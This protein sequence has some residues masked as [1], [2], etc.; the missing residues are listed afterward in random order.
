MTRPLEPGATIGILGGGQLGRLLAIAAAELGYRPAIF[1]PDPLSPA[2]HVCDRHWQAPYDSRAALAEFADAVDIVTFE[3]ENVPALSLDFL[4]ARVPI[5]PSQKALATTQDRLIEKKFIADLGIPVAPFRDVS[6]ADSLKAAGVDLGFPVIAKTRRLGY[7]GK[8]QV[9]LEAASDA[10]HAWASLASGLVIAE[11]VISFDREVSVILARGL[12]G[13]IRPWSVT[14]NVH[15]KG[16]LS[17]SHVPALVSDQINSKALS[18]AR[19]IADALGFV[20]VM[21]VEMFVIDKTGDVIVNEIAPRVHNSGHWTLDGALTSQF[22]QHIRAIC[23]LPLGDPRALG[24]VHMENL[25]G[26]DIDRWQEL[27]HDPQA[28]LH[29]YGKSVTRPGRKMGHV[30]WV[31][32]D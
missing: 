32:P 3:F 15:H 5:R 1:C 22:E 26:A 25:I 27:L 31:D 6:D 28:C 13:T 23:G 30:T 24:R 8:G 20:G 11:Q 19:T 17:T 7:D 16:I 14:E 29:H 21:A 2:F 4:E 10:D 9:R 18:H 12:D